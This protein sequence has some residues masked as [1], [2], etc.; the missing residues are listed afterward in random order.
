MPCS[1]SGPAACA[2]FPDAGSLGVFRSLGVCPASLVTWIEFQPFLSFSMPLLLCL[3]AGVAGIVHPVSGCSHYGDV[4]LV[5]GEVTLLPF[6]YLWVVCFW[7]AFS[8]AF[9]VRHDFGFVDAYSSL[10]L[11]LWVS[12]CVSPPGCPAFSW[13]GVDPS[14]WLPLLWPG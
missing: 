7:P 6:P 10:G 3:Q 5:W 1:S 14:P 13:V 2:A 9:V 11:P 8:Q 4:S 12:A